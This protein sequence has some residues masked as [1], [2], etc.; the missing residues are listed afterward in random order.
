MKELA[1]ALGLK[2]ASQVSN[3]ENEA[4]GPSK[5]AIVRLAEFFGKDTGFF[6]EGAS[7]A[8]KS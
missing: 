4:N 6:L 1:E 5:T 7:T 8:T 2:H 3:W